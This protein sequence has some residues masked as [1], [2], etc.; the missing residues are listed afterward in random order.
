MGI[1]ACLAFTIGWIGSC[2]L[3]LRPV[4]ALVRS[5]SRLAAGEF[6]IRT[7]LAHRGDELGQLTRT[8]D[9][10]AQALEHREVERQSADHALKASELRYR[11]LFETAQDGILILNAETG[12]I[13][14]VNPFLTDLLGYSR[15]QL[16]GNKL[17][18]IG[19]FK[20]TKASKSGFRE[21]QRETYI[22]YEDLPLET[23]AGKSI[24]VEF[25][26]NVYG[27]NGRKVIQ[28]NIRDITERKKAE[29]KRKEF[30]RKL[31]ALSRRLVEVQ[32]SERR[33]LARELHDE[34]GQSLTAIELNLQALLEL[35]GADALAPR[36]KASMEVVE[37]VQEQ[38]HDLSLNLRPS[39]LDDLG[40]EPA[41]RWYTDRQAALAGLQ[42][43]VRADP[44][45]QR[46]DPMIETQCFRVAQEALTN[47]VKHA[48]AHTVTVE[49]TRNDEQIHLSVRDDGVG[50]DL[51]SVREQAVR[52]AS[53]GLLSMEER[54]TLAGG[55]LH[56]HTHP[57]QGTEVHAWFPLKWAHPAVL[58]GAI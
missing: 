3:V 46:L 43:E 11:R 19:P 5:S 20:D 52:G 33:H 48:K 8:F 32:E 4:R 31:Q 58:I 25:V 44:M 37:R 40:L 2:L 36:L 55:G 47:V 41:L 12:Q 18:D 6:S 13:D 22:R 27:V 56:Y 26:S 34:I 15:E 29:A 45:G 17:W 39:I 54:A 42:A 50:F 21:L 35:P 28:C 49:L 53:L 9:Q 30:S 10:M 23:S 16:L 1:A 57:G 14:D 38:V 24:N 7:G 51:A